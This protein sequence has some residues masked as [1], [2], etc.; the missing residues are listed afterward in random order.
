MNCNAGSYHSE[1][2]AVYDGESKKVKAKYSLML[3][4]LSK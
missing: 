2:T 3:V 4:V 1:K